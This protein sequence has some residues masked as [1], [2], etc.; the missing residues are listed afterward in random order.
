MGPLG[1]LMEENLRRSMLL[2]R[3]DPM[4]FVDHPISLGLLL[5]TVALLVVLVV[6]NV[7]KVRE[8]AFVE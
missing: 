1:P 3:G 8:Q 7:R 2:S 4:I 5:V 6:P